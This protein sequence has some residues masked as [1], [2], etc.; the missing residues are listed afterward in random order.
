MDEERTI[1]EEPD[2]IKVTEGQRAENKRLCDKFPFLIPSNRWSGKKINSGED[3]YWPGNQGVIPK[4]NYEY[5]E[6]DDMPDG[7]RMAFGEQM[8]EEILEELRANNMVDKYRI[9]QI[10][11]KYGQLRFYDNGFTQHGYDIISKYTEISERT[12]INCGKPATKIS[13]GWISPW[14]DDCADSVYDRMVP[15]DEFYAEVSDI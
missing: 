3:G 6:L 8:C 1:Y 5:T 11:E 9:L 7:W 10:K 14:C 2:V 4:W 15:I 12:C 13:T